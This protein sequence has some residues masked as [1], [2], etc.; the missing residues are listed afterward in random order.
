MSTPAAPAAPA[1]PQAPAAPPAAKPAEPPAPASSVPEK[2]AAPPAAEKPAVQPVTEP[3]VE[4]APPPAPP[5][6]KPAEPPA[7]VVPEKYD[8]KIPDGA[9]AFLTQADLEPIIAIAREHKLDNAGAQAL[10]TQHAEAVANASAAHRAVT[11]ADPTYG[12]EHLDETQQLAKL[13][14]DTIRPAGT[15]RGDGLR[16]L[17][18]R[19][20][21]G[22]HLE[23]VSFLA[24][25]GRTMREDTPVAGGARG[26]PPK[27]PAQV[28]YGATTDK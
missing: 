1:N 17:L 10:V 13:A 14:L 23:V 27:D 16:Q 28:L 15:P 11:E 9:E 26:R 19:S 3:P 4:G 12:G 25:L 24:D 20:G 2:P 5:A 22:N 8:L 7:P 6:A 18:A 21:Y